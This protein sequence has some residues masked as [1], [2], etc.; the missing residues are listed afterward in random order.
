M[1]EV[2][3]DR[4]EGG[5]AGVLGSELDDEAEEEI[6]DVDA[7]AARVRLVDGGVLGL[8]VIL[9]ADEEEEDVVEEEG[10]TGVCDRGR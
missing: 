9:A 3:G 8:F 5:V 6:E 10:D 4:S 2:R 7:S 1:R